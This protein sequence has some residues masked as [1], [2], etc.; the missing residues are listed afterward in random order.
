MSKLVVSDRSWHY[1]IYATPARIIGEPAPD[2]QSLCGYFW[3]V[4][5][6]VFAIPFLF[7]GFFVLVKPVKWIGAK[8][9]VVVAVLSTAIITASLTTFLWLD[10]LRTLE[11]M[12]IVA[13][14]V[15]GFVILCVIV[16][17]SAEGWRTRHPPKPKVETAKTT[18]LFWEMLKVKK[19]RVCPPLEVH[20]S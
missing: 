17:L 7:L 4:V 19:Q 8:R 10:W 1:R 14:C 18:R 6:S 5:V 16:S 12:G 13:G 11:V 20:H 9:E 15:V 3:T 2:P